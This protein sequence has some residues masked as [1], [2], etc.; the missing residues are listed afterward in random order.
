MKHMPLLKPAMALLAGVGF[1][2][3]AHA[4]IPVVDGVHAAISQLGVAEN[5]AQTAKQI[6]EYKTQLDQYTTQALQY[7]KQLDQYENMIKNTTAPAAYLWDEANST[8]NKLMQAQDMINYYTT[9]AGSLDSYLSKFQDVNYYRSSSCFQLGGCSDSEKA[10]IER[11]EDMHSEAQKEANAAMFKGIAQQQ[12][13]LKSDA[14]RL[15]QLQGAAS[16]AD[17]QVKAIQYASQIASQQA[18]QL[19]Q[20]RGLMLAQQ[21]AMAAKAAAEQDQQ[22]RDTAAERNMTSGSFN[23]PSPQTW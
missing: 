15:E 1:T 16:T 19:L 3:Q 22:A 9:Q 12:E 23:K 2:L 20:I 11:S 13:N 21:N 17:G 10:A 8:I 4:G 18:N 6:Q 5:I 14:R 7:K